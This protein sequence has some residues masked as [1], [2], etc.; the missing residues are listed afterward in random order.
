MN[1]KIWQFL[2]LTVMLVTLFTITAFTQET[3]TNWSAWVGSHYTGIDNYYQKVAEFDRGKDGA[4]PEIGLRFSRL[5]GKNHLQVNGHY[6]DP[7]RM[8]VNVQANSG[9]L[10][11]ASVSY[12]SFYRQKQNDL[13]ANLEV[14]EAADREGSKPAGKFITHESTPDELFGYK[15]QEIKTN[16]EIKVPGKSGLKFKVS[17][18]TLI[19][20]GHEQRLTTMHSSVGLSFSST[21]TTNLAKTFFPARMSSSPSETV[22]RYLGADA[23]CNLSPPA[24]FRV[25]IPSSALS[26][27]T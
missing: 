5:S 13:L 25:N 23:L 6:Y 11:S 22:T 18:R 7:K 9:D 3:Q 16:V 12:K 2:V 4:T 26:D 27:R 19:D 17:H 1:E 15:R 8:T 24:S 21:S 10:V 20:Q 14:R